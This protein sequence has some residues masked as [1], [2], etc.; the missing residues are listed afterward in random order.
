MNG[1]VILLHG[2]L[3]SSAQMRPLADL[4]DGPTSCPDLHGHGAL[5]DDVRPYSIAGFAQDVA[6]LIKTPMHLLGYSMGGYIA[7]YLAARF[8]DKVRSVTTIATKLDWTPEGAAQEVRMLN[9]EKVREKVPAFAAQL[10][11]RH[12]SHWTQVM[13]RT[14]QLMLSLGNAPVLTPELLASVKCPV[15]L[16]R[17]S[18]DNMVSEEETL[19]AEKHIPTAHFI[20]LQ[21]QPHP[22]ERMDLRLI[23]DALGK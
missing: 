16:M 17:G 20:N 13:E 2:A 10:E 3:G 7:L 23:V 18:D 12:G 15:K 1:N 21:G 4:L 11:S 6:D 14:A 5:S 8:P 22:I 9:P 19:W